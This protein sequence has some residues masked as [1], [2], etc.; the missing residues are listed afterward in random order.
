[1]QYCHNEKNAPQWAIV[2]GQGLYHMTPPPH[3]PYH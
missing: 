3:I 1:M 2:G